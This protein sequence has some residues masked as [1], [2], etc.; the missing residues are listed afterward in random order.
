MTERSI[1]F[2]VRRSR[3]TIRARDWDIALG[4]MPWSRV[5]GPFFHACRCVSTEVT[6]RGRV[7]R[8][9]W[10]QPKPARPVRF[11]GGRVLVV[12]PVISNAVA[13][14]LHGGAPQLPRGRI[15]IRGDVTYTSYW[16]IQAGA[17]H[18]AMCF[19]RRRQASN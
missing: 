8:R 15:R 7:L 1:R 19:A 18:S 17:R 4:A 2:V 11:T 12:D 14:E 13:A 10:P 3:P 5:T 16:R 6:P 9:P